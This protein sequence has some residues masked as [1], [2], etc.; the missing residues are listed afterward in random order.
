MVNGMWVH[1]VQTG[2][3]DVKG[4]ESPKSPKQTYEGVRASDLK[5]QAQITAHGGSSLSRLFFLLLGDE[6]GG[7][8]HGV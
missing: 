6:D 1:T 8:V 2:V 5:G 7:R 4:Q 3:T